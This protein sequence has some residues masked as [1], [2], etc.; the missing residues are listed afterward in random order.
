MGARRAAGLRSQRRCGAA[1][2]RA[3]G[4]EP[5]IS[6]VGF[7]SHAWRRR[8]QRPKIRTSA[9]TVRARRASTARSPRAMR[10]HT[11]ERYRIL[12]E[13]EF[14]ADPSVGLRAEPRLRPHGSRGRRLAVAT[15]LFGAVASV[16]GVAAASLLLSHRDPRFARGSRRAPSSIALAV[17]PRPPA[18]RARR[19]AG[20]P[21]ARA[22]R[23][24]DL[25]RSVRRM[26]RRRAARSRVAP[27]HL[28]QAVA[29]DRVDAGAAPDAPATAYRR[30]VIAEPGATA[31]PDGAGEFGFER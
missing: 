6:P 12:S 19:E 14:F 3:R 18:A 8:R 27:S 15:V 26:S 16:A 7:R 10:R 24:R 22:R 17:P 31:S 25:V 28:R 21:R 30:K 1:R 4:R 5:P 13:E 20:R 29:T 23:D 11:R 9:M 2:P